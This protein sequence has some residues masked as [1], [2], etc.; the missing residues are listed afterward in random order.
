[1]QVA[2]MVLQYDN[3]T[4]TTSNPK[5]VQV[6]VPGF[7]GTHSI[8]QLTSGSSYP[9]FAYI[10]EALVSLGYVRNKNLKGAP[11]DFRKAPSKYKIFSKYY[12]A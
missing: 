7:G 8:E 10:A 11:F 9:Y 3:K 5:G 6:R 12:F 1:M 4:R 2:N